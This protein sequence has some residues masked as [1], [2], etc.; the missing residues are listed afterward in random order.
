MHHILGTLMNETFLI[1]GVLAYFK[2]KWHNWPYE[3]V[4]E[5][6]NASACN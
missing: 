3:T 6:I 1:C 2:W 5:L 4:G